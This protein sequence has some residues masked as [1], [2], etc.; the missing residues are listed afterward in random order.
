MKILHIVG[1]E[2]SNGA[3]RGA[4]W[5]HSGLQKMDVK[6][7]VF[8]NSKNT[9]GDESVVSITKSKKG[10]I[11]NIIRDQMGSLPCLFYSQ[12]EKFI[13]STGIFGANFTKTKEYK[14]ADVIH[15]HWINGLVNIKDLK[16]IK[17]PII[18]TM[19]DMWPMTG[20]CH[21]AESLKCERYKVGCGKCKQLNSN[22]RFDLSYFILKRKKKYLP[23]NIRIIGISSWLSEKAKESDLFKKFNVR[24]IHNNINADIFFPIDKKNAKN[25]VGLKT[26][27]KVILVGS[28]AL[29]VPWKGFS[30]YLE[31]IQRL[32]SEKY[33]LCL[34]GN[35][36]KRVVESLGFEYKSFGFL[37]DSISLRL[38]Y[39]AADVFVAPSI[40]DAFGKTIAESMACGTPT[41]CFN[42]TGPKDIV[43]HKV[44]GYKAQP[45]NAVELATGIEWVLNALNYDE[46]CQNARDKVIKKFDSQ[47][48]AK[49][50][51]KLYEEVLSD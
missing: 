8:T 25:I 32:D 14:E 37:H 35:V 39:S 20:G 6:S 34:F 22:W 27:K 48:I 4:Y 2:L 51:I 11:I 18:W 21:V 12:R 3:A 42:S 5:L 9:L 10:K 44:D 33:F 28:A 1:G 40:M 41:V 16:K 50:Y 36:D 19:R 30:K 45:Y 15:L 46:L 23:K 47:V 24:T 38:V 26:E 7:K 43:T 29:S 13:F 17:K 49:Q 31:A